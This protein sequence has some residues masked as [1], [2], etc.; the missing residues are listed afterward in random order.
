MARETEILEYRSPQYSANKANLYDNITKQIN[1]F[2]A[3]VHRVMHKIQKCY[4]C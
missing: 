2:S 4:L 3:P 1:I